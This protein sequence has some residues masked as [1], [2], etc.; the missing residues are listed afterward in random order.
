MLVRGAGCGAGCGVE[1]YWPAVDVPRGDA[2]LILALVDACAPTA[3][4]EPVGGV[5]LFF[6]DAGNRAEAL[7][8]LAR[9]GIAAAAVEV[10]D[11]NWAER[12][13]AD[14][15]PVTVGR[16]TVVPTPPNP[17]SPIPDPHAITIPPSTAFGTGHHATTRLC[18]AALQRLDLEGQSVLDVGTGAGLLAIAAARLGARSVLGID[19]DPD[20]VRTAADNLRLNTEPNVRVEI[21]DVRTLAERPDHAGPFD[22]VVANLTAALIVATAPD[23]VSVTRPGGHLVLSGILTPERLEVEMALGP[24]TPI[25]QD[26]ED[27]WVGLVLARRPCP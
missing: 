2:D 21:A 15:K 23:L 3:M 18:L 17:P 25:W 22:V 9:H 27:G 1:K 13:Q 11:E 7:A 12:S 19:N 5:R 26:E 16:L 14:L 6:N 8:L 4:D 10:S 20:A 24:A